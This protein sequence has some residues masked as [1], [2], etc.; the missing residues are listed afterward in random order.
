MGDM[1]VYLVQLDSGKT[2]R[3]TQPNTCAT[4]RIAAPGRSAFGSAGIRSSWRGRHRIVSLAAPH[5]AKQS[6]VTAR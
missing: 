6:Y 3:V 4:P 5:M 1:S 2:V